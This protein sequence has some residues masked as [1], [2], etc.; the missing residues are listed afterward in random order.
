M[1]QKSTDLQKP[2]KRALIYAQTY[3][4]NTENRN[5]HQDPTNARTVGDRCCRHPV[6][7]RQVYALPAGHVTSEA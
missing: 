4:R 7:P 1:P 2:I 5:S 6:R 3:S